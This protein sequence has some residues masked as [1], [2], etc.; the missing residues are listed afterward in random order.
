MFFRLAA[1][2]IVLIHL[3]FIGFVL[4]GGFFA[5]HWR[6][7]SLVHLP[8]VLW[9]ALIEFTGGICP[10]T[11]LEQR[12]RRMAGETGYGGGF[13]DHYVIPLIYPAWLA[14]P[15]QLALGLLVIFVN[16]G[17]YG[18]LAW[19]WLRRRHTS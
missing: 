5:L 15:V 11:P 18:W 4:F 8:A 2:L 6:R 7:F 9:G 17:V 3:A 14:R 10:L 1:D 12:L 13:I 19:H 16:L